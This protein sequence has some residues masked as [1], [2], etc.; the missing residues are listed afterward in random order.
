LSNVIAQAEK[1]FRSPVP[2]WPS[3]TTNDLVYIAIETF[4]RETKTYQRSR[5]GKFEDAKLVELDKLLHQDRIG[6]W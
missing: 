1:V 5:Q 2:S 4:D 6:A 3:I